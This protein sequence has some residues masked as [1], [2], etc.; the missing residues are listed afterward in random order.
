M[1]KALQLFVYALV[2]C[3]VGLALWP[4]QAFRNT[5]FQ[6][7]SQRIFLWFYSD[8]SDIQ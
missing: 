5:E 3:Q 2:P 1:I 4:D 8:P 7:Q 6:N